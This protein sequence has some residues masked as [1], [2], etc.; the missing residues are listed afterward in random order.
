MFIINEWEN[1]IRQK[2]RIESQLSK[3][4]TIE[5]PIPSLV[6]N[7]WQENGITGWVGFH[8]QFKH[9][10]LKIW[11]NGRI[12]EIA[13]CQRESNWIISPYRGRTLEDMFNFGIKNIYQQLKSNMIN[14]IPD[15]DLSEAFS[16][17]DI[18]IPKFNITD[19][20]ET[21]GSKRWYDDDDSTRVRFYKNFGLY[22]IFVRPHLKCFSCR[23]RWAVYCKLHDTSMHLK[24]YENLSEA[25]SIGVPELVK[26]IKIDIR[27]D[28]LAFC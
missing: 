11:Y 18:D 1:K 22:T 10:L 25:F 9:F 8:K 7:G 12:W 26:K 24:I 19:W 20:K 28:V 13:Y 15:I 17:S 4:E 6:M 21:T 5:F 3:I 16:I 14:Q 27:N 2:A 23:Y